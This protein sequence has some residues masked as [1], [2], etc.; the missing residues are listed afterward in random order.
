M[1]RIVALIS[2]TLLMLSLL[3]VPAL[4]DESP[5]PTHTNHDDWIRWTNAATLPSEDGRY[6]L[7]ND[8]EMSAPIVL[9]DKNITLC[10]NGKT[11]KQVGT[12]DYERFYRINGS[13]AVAICDCTAHVDETGKYVAGVM[14]G[15]TN[16]AFLFDA[17]SSATLTL[18]DGILTGNSAAAGGCIVVQ[19]K[20]YFNMYGGEISD[21]HARNGNGGGIY[22]SASSTVAI[23]GGTISGNTATKAEGVSRGGGLFTSAGS[24]SLQDVVISGNSADQ[25]AGV[26]VN[27]GTTNVDDGTAIIDN[28]ASIDGGGI[29][30]ANQ[31]STHD[32]VLLMQNGR[33]AGNTADTGGA[34]C[35]GTGSEA[36][37]IG[38]TITGNT[39]LTGVGG[40]LAAGTLVLGNVTITENV[41]GMAGGVHFLQG[42]V[43]F[44][45]SPVIVDNTLTDGTACNLLYEAQDGGSLSLLGIGSGTKI[46]VTLAA[47]LPGI[48]ATGANDDNAAYFFSDNVEGKVWYATANGFELGMMPEA[49]EPPATQPTTEATEPT[50]EEPDDEEHTPGSPWVWAAV[51]VAVAGAMATAL[52]V[53]K[54]K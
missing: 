26:Y 42:T 15:A 44:D 40:I 5:I 20:S 16:S 39:A 29:R 43:K 31:D 19:G 6:V 46:G 27:N 37:L 25:G 34:L 45:G 53:K 52:A 47:G 3:P 35:M 18:Y 12:G 33:I 11:V 30:I 28:V 38:G 14:T 17:D 32:P 21:N 50:D 7:M 41:G 1:K 8:I 51:A 48:T 36:K 10:L 49:T 22:A 2:A 23:L 4:A 9:E 13:T 54:K 24:C